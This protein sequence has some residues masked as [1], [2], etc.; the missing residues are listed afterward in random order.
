MTILQRALTH[1]E[2]SQF[3]REAAGKV[4]ATMLSMELEPGHTRVGRS[5]ADQH[6]GII[7]TLGL[8]GARKGSGQLLFEP[9]LACRAASAMLMTEYTTVDDDVIDVVA[10]TGNM[11]VGNIK[12]H[13]ETRLG[14]MGLSTPV[15]VYGGEFETRT[16]GN[17]DWVIVPFRC[18]GDSV[19]VQL[20]LTEGPGNHAR[21]SWNGAPNANG[22]HLHH[23][24]HTG[25]R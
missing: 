7:V 16:A 5:A 11:V 13:L 22:A 17:P 1:S 2:I 3:I 12:N 10:E 20:A 23:E 21:H 6:S 19:I 8:T 24:N 18:G 4:F 15:I 25:R 9:A 14:P